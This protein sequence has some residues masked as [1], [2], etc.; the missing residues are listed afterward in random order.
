MFT[1]GGQT[2]RMSGF[3]SVG[4]AR[5]QQPRL[6]RPA[7]FS[8]QFKGYIFRAKP[9]GCCRKAFAHPFF[10]FVDWRGGGRGG[11]FSRGWHPSHRQVTRGYG[12]P[13][14]PLSW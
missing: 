1:R 10:L 5:L 3:K 6:V 8:L 9:P 13:A 4:R 2:A 14:I 11:E 7:V 12:S